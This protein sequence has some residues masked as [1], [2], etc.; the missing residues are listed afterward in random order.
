[1]NKRL[2]SKSS[3]EMA[4]LLFA[5]ECYRHKII[6]AFPHTDDIPYD[7]IIDNGKRLLKIQVK[8][9]RHQKGSATAFT[10]NYNVSKHSNNLD[11][12]ALYC[13]KTN[14]FYIVPVKKI[15]TNTFYG[16]KKNQVYK[17]NW[18]LLKL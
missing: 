4:E 5:A 14:D 7:F 18:Q 15:K 11:F 2:S 8:S 16:S 10:I 3:G 17:N 6:V 9:S 12:Y 13:Y 1:M